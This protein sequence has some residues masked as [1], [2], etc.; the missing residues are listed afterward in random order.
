MRPNPWGQ[1]LSGNP[2]SQSC[3]YI[4]SNQTEPGKK[5]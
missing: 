4:I 5:V 1:K 3:T 2:V